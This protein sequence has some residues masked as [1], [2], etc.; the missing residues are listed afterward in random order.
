MNLHRYSVGEF[1]ELYPDIRPG[2]S[3]PLSRSFSAGQT[4]GRRKR[5]VRFEELFGMLLLRF[6]ESLDF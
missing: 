6:T 5:Q 4:P 3:V 2:R 1:K